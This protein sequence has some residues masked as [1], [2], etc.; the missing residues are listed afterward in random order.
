MLGPVAMWLART[1]VQ[2]CHGA[3]RH[4]VENKGDPM[5]S[6]LA[7]RGAQRRGVG[8]GARVLMETRDGLLGDTEASARKG[9]PG[10]GRSGP[11]GS[12]WCVAAP[13]RLGRPDTAPWRP[14]TA[15]AAGSLDLL[16]PSQFESPST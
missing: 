2:L 4:W 14:I 13:G 7:P 16:M 1:R 11:R 10:I 8:V 15:P 5:M 3:S 9:V 6:V 12:G